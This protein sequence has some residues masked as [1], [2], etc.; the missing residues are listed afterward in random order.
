MS[1]YILPPFSAKIEEKQKMESGTEFPSGKAH[2][3]RVESEAA[4]VER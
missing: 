4:K 1:V 3:Q 2:G